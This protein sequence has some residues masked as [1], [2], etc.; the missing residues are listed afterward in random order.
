MGLEE[1]RSSQETISWGTKAAKVAYRRGL[2]SRV[3]GYG[4]EMEGMC[5]R[6]A[7]S[8]L[9]KPL[10]CVVGSSARLDRLTGRELYPPLHLLA[11]SQPYP[12]SASSLLYGCT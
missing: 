1:S 7:S 9:E 12:M 5:P 3:D 2:S 11:A 10:A 8:S 4:D 6:V